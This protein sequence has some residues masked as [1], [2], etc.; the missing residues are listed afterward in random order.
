MTELDFGNIYSSNGKVI[1]HRYAQ[2]AID[3]GSTMIAMRNSKCAVL[4]V[5]KPIISNLHIIEN[6]QRIKKLSSNAYMTYT[7]LLTDG[8]LIHN[9][10]KKSIRDYVSNYDSEITTNYLKKIITEYVYM[11][12]SNLSSRAIGASFFT[13]IKEE[14]EYN[15]LFTDCTGKVTKWNACA[16]GKGERRA[17]TELE[18]LDLEK[19]SIEEMVDSGIKILYKCFDPITDPE[20]IIEVGYMSDEFVRIDQ[21]KIEEISEKYKD[22]SMEED[23]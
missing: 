23:Y 1:Q 6:D 7:G 14:G 16:A 17:F 5:C 4:F 10:C 19:M 8:L 13:I 11:F 21:S 12:T 9:I 20:F 3:A 2:K 18:K 15:L 22:M